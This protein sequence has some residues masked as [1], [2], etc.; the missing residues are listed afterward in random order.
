MNKLG[1]ALSFTLLLLFSPLAGTFNLASANP[2]S[3]AIY[4]GTIDA[5]S[6]PLIENSPVYN[7]SVYN[8]N[9]LSIPINV[10]LT[11]TSDDAYREFISKV[12][13]KSDWLSDEPI[14]YK[15]YN[16]DSNNI[17]PPITYLD[18]TLNLTG[19]P[20]GKHIL[21]FYAVEGGYYYPSLFEYYILSSNTSAT[22]AF[23]IDTEPPNISI[24]SIAS[25]TLNSPIPLNFTTSEPASKISFC[26]SST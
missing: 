24:L 6:L 21:T 17:K 3:Q 13:Y 26:Y 22:I 10:S 5:P 18:Y 2:Y 16:P 12:Y 15:Y 4:Q 7:N 11:T 19:L 1:L 20:N 23:T 25:K 9:S 14:I 8:K